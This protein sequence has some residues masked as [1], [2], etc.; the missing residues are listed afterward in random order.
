LT[1]AASDEPI[2]AATASVMARR[3]VGCMI[4]LLQATL[5]RT[6]STTLRK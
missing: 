5:T 3:T 2:N 6:V 1:G 4:G